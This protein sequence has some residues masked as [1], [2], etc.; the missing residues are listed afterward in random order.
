M[1]KEMGNVSKRQQPDHKAYLTFWICMKNSK[2][3]VKSS[4][5]DCYKNIALF[6][7]FFLFHICV[8][9]H[10]VYSSLLSISIYIAVL[11][12]I[13]RIFRRLVRTLHYRKHFYENQLNHFVRD[14]NIS[15][16]KSYVIIS[17]SYMNCYLFHLN[18][19]SFL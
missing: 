18:W 1:K 16:L 10:L 7:Y 8:Y 14:T 3:S 19:S 13:L 9:C 6:S 17:T 15:V 12:D 2:L 5:L 4:E 11:I